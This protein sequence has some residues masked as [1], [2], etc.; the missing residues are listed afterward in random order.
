MSQDVPYRPASA[1]ES[2]MHDRDDTAIGCQNMGS[3]FGHRAK[4]ESRSSASES[5][6]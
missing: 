5:I 2:G 4:R 6:E 3:D 1:T